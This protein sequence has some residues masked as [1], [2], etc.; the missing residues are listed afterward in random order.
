MALL[1]LRTALADPRLDPHAPLRLAPVPDGACAQCHSGPATSDDWALHLPAADICHSCH[2]DERHT[3]VSTHLDHSLEPA[4]AA[5]ASA[6]ELPLL[7]GRI[8]CVT[9]HDVHPK[10]AIAPASPPGWFVARFGPVA[11]GTDLARVAGP[12]LCTACHAL[13]ELP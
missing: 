3:G 2:A 1:L 5:R 11:P 7:D 6:A 12:A 9:C 8:G 10:T 13:Q 4:M